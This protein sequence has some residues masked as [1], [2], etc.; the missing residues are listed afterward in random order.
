MEEREALKREIE[1]LQNL[2]NTHKSIHGD[3][4]FSR[5][6]QRHPGASTFSRGRGHSSSVIHPHSSRGRA[7]DPQSRGS[8]RKTYSL[9][10]KTPQRSVGPSSASASSSGFQSSSTSIPNSTSLPSHSR[11]EGGDGAKSSALLPT[12]SQLRREVQVK[13]IPGVCDV[14]TEKRNLV[15]YQKAA[16][17]QHEAGKG[18]LGSTSVGTQHHNLPR[19]PQEVQQRLEH[20]HV[21]L[22][23]KKAS[24]SAGVPS[25]VKASTSTSLHS[26]PLKPSLPGKT[27]TESQQTNTA[28]PPAHLTTGH[29]IV[30]PSALSRISKQPAVK[31][32]PPLNHSR[33]SCSKK[34]KFTWVKS[35]NVEAAQLKQASPVFSSPGRAASVSPILVSKAGVAGRFSPSSSTS[36]RAPSRKLPRKL[37]PVTVAPKTSKYKWVSSSAGAQAKISRKSPSPKALSLS[38]KALEKGEATKKQRTPPTLSSKIKKGNTSSSSSPS[39][40]SQYRWKAGGLSS[41]A[42]PG[43]VTVARRKSAFHWTSDKSYKHQKAGLTS[44]PSQR[45]FITPSPGGFKLRSRMKII[46]KSATS[47]GGSEKGSSPSA[48]KLSPRS[49]IHSSTRSPT[50]AKRTPSRELVSFGRHKLRRLSLTSSRTSLAASSSTSSSSLRSPT[51]QGVFRTRYKMV[52]RPGSSTAHTPHFNPALAWR[53]KRIQS[54]RSFLQNRLRAP[55]HRHSQPWRG[56]NMC[57]IGGSLYRVSANKLSRTVASNMSI[58]RTGRSYGAAQV[59]PTIYNRPSSTRHLASRAVQRSLAIIRHARHKK[60]Q[61]QY[62]MYYNRFGKCNRGNSCPYIHDPDK[63]AVC[64]RF[65]RGTCKQADGTCPFSHKVAK[66]KMPVC[67]YFLKG[68]C[69]NSDCPYSHVY[70]SRKAEVCE[71]FVKGYCPEGEKCKK[72]HTLVCPDFS[73]TGS[74]PRGTSCKLQHRQRVKRSASTSST[75]STKKVRTKEPTKRPRLSVVMPQSSQTESQTPPRGSLALPA[76]I[77]LSSS[78][79]EAD[80]P[81][82]PTAEGSQVKEKKL[83]IKPRL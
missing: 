18:G 48:V 46:R 20:K 13:S 6:D 40:S 44:P 59:S 15:I 33:A 77:S 71:D 30:P 23:E 5:V 41:T 25:P 28:K 31:S 36:K 79:E 2:I 80:T 74:C 22:P 78:P 10:N 66:E 3:T 29:S 76:F 81:D 51:S 67:S 68:I 21:D 53:T 63:V 11:Q 75:T 32:P 58:N 8:W 55:H 43:G 50:G 42:V 16:G 45:S 7:Y 47:G 26:S 56:S 64:T 12:V 82:T 52:T 19:Q 60:Q 34:S 39:L 27:S 49:R 83:Q 72:K 62:C 14:S 57:W 65:L 4:P 54:A 70:V 37:S 38:H 9:K 24:V 73:K 35:Q 61:K 69:N 17:S 1:L